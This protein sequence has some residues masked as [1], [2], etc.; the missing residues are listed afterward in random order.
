MSIYVDKTAKKENQ[1]ISNSSP[2]QQSNSDSAFQLVDNRPEAIAQRS[3]QEAISNTSSV[4]NKTEPIQKKQNHTGLPDQLKTGIENLSGYSMDDVKVHYNSTK[5]VQLNAHAYAQGTNI[6]MTNGQEKHLAHETWHVVQQKQGRVKPTLQLKG[7]VNVNDDKNLE[8]EADVMGNTA[9]KLGETHQRKESLIISRPILNLQTL[10]LQRMVEFSGET[11]SQLTIGPPP[12]KVKF[13]RKR[14]V[15]DFGKA[16]FRQEMIMTPFLQRVQ[17]IV[18]ALLGKTYKV[19]LDYFVHHA[20]E[21]IASSAFSEFTIQGQKNILEKV[22]LLNQLARSEVRPE[23]RGKEIDELAKIYV[24]ALDLF[25]HSER[26][27]TPGVDTPPS[28]KLN[29]VPAD[30][31]PKP[32]WLFL[33]STKTFA[34]YDTN[35]LQNLTDAERYVKTTK[36][37]WS[38]LEEAHYNNILLSGAA[39]VLMKPSSGAHYLDQHE[40]TPLS[41]GPQGDASTYHRSANHPLFDGLGKS[42]KA[43]VLASMVV[44]KD[45]IRPKKKGG[46]GESHV[47]LYPNTFTFLRNRKVKPP[48]PTSSLVPKTMDRGTGDLY[49]RSLDYKLSLCRRATALTGKLK[50]L[51]V[52]VY[53]NYPLVMVH[54]DLE[55][56]ITAYGKEV[57]TMPS[58]GTKK[59]FTKF[60]MNYYTGLVNYFAKSAGINI[61]MVERSSFGFNTPSIAETGQSF[62]LNLG[63]MPPMY[64]NVQAH[65]LRLLDAQ[66]ADLMKNKAARN[67]RN[68]KL[69]ATH[70]Y[71]AGKTQAINAIDDWLVFALYPVESRGKPAI[72]NATRK[73]ENLDFI[74]ARSFN[75]MAH[76][77]GKVNGLGMVLSHLFADMKMKGDSVSTDISA[78][79][80]KYSY[81]VPSKG[82]PYSPDREIEAN[83]ASFLMLLRQKVISVAQQAQDPELNKQLR[84]LMPLIIPGNPYIEKTLDLVNELFII[85]AVHHLESKKSAYVDDDYGSDSEVEEDEERA[86]KDSPVL[87]ESAAPVKRVLTGKKI[88]THNGMRALLSSID[89]AV[90]IVYK[91][92][93][94]LKIDIEGAYYEMDDAVKA[95]KITATITG[96]GP[97]DAHILVRDI[98]AC[99][100]DGGKS[101]MVIDPSLIESGARAWI[102][103]TTSATQAQM[104]GLVEGFRKSHATA[105]YLVSSG[106]KQEQFG[107]DRNQ[108]GTVRVFTDKK[109]K[110]MLGNIL[111]TIKAS[112]KPLAATAHIYR[113]FMKSIG[114]VPRNTFILRGSKDISSASKKPDIESEW[115]QFDFSFLK[116]IK[117]T[118]TKHEL[119]N[120]FSTALLTVPVQGDDPGAERADHSHHANEFIHAGLAKSVK[121]SESDKNWFNILANVGGGDCLLHALEAK[122]LD[123]AEVLALRAQLS[124]SAAHTTAA[125]VSGSSVYQS[126]YQSGLMTSTLH[127]RMQ[128][129]HQ[130]PRAVYQAAIRIPG[131]YAGEEEIRAFCH[132]RG[133]RVLIVTNTGELRE[134]TAGGAAAVGSLTSL[135][136]EAFLARIA[137]YGRGGAIV[138]YK[139]PNHWEKIT[140]LR[141]E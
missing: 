120:A 62:R 94:K 16:F 30:A 91:N 106:F 112:D 77:Q 39:D 75:I 76:F 102:I 14:I 100:T 89:S 98:N 63:L 101:K 19:A 44:R 84:N 109:A 96:D 60:L 12:N 56:F 55:G 50:Y 65:A 131:L 58:D 49:D 116:D 88:I 8:K 136:K 82:N 10:P 35:P 15:T 32:Q 54:F 29:V 139:S 90:K 107:A 141:A 59:A 25:F 105:L 7:K 13:K 130:I 21:M 70:E 18:P 72:S 87:T 126:L 133:G 74:N 48:V 53:N 11:I 36:A 26:E 85:H 2:K 115:E 69:D 4:Q 20:N 47:G 99:V 73:R 64:A 67:F 81:K 93:K 41:H 80:T 114:A 108:Y 57:D 33:F 17:S 5:P 113:R 42:E 128:N 28:L 45:S 127:E 22:I 34:V 124:A 78:E 125:T 46:G 9:L 104:N 79:E 68:H 140:S 27:A 52:G 31:S 71:F 135:G 97:G 83:Y 134:V 38:G 117:D 110:V 61:T 111:N 132:L 51:T 92:A 129:K 66:L 1:T 40:H 37:K 6:H 23:E 118:Q 137:E 24:M 86:S 123:F 138:L 119:V 103:D 95:S 122:N 121:K 3:L 43:R